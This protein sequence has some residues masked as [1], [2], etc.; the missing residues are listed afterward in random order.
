MVGKKAVSEKLLS[1]AIDIGVDLFNADN[2]KACAAVYKIAVMAVLEIK[3]KALDEKELASIEKTLAA[4][5]GSD[6]QRANAWSLRRAMDAI[7]AKL[8]K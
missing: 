8:S 3:P 5:N 7:L 2:E 1:D 4:V 6:D